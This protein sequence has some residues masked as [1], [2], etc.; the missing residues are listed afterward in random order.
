MQGTP[1]LPPSFRR[2]LRALCGVLAAFY[3]CFS[4]AGEITIAVASNFAAP[5]RDIAAAFERVSGEHR[6][7]LAFGS[8]GKLYAQVYHG[9]PFDA[10]FSA[11]QDKVN[12]L[13]ARD[14]AVSNS[15]L[16]YALGQLALWSADS[17]LID[18]GPAVLAG[19][20][21]RKLAIANPKL[22]PYGVAAMETLTALEF[23]Q[24]TRGR[25]VLGENI[26]Q[27][28]QFVASGNAQLGLIALSQVYRDGK[29]TGGSSW[30]VPQALYRPIRQDAVI[31]RNI[32][33]G[34][35]ERVAATKAFWAFLRSPKARSII[36]SY[37]YLTNAANPEPPTT[38]TKEVRDAK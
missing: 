26:A 5:M 34:P 32:S 3:S 17:A 11:D 36:E 8:S 22:A 28:F 12:R 35:P 25:R 19:D 33:A 21:F 14:L 30:L 2:L 38:S 23:E 37:G 29:I 27:A 9:A 4:A 24:T 1:A 7:R 16:T 20:R 18:E 31:L 6:L 10:F 13:I 15:R